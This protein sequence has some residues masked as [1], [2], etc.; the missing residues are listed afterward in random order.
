MKIEQVLR[1]EKQVVYEVDNQANE[2]SVYRT[3]DNETVYIYNEDHEFLIKLTLEPS[4]GE[5]GG[6]SEIIIG[7]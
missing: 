1:I 2:L 7:N 4:F 3:I 5:G 6:V